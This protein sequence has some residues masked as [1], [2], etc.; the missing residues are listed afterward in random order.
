[1]RHNPSDLL[2]LDLRLE[3]VAFNGDEHLAQ[4]LG[5]NHVVQELNSQTAAQIRLLPGN[6]VQR[7]KGAE[8]KEQRQ[9][10]IQILEGIDEGGIALLDNVIEFDFGKQGQSTL[11]V[12]EILDGTIAIAL[13]GK[14]LW[15]IWIG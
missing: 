5:R 8:Q 13:L 4:R 1:M 3:V 9:T 11:Q 7:G 10:I 12:A 14:D 6:Q 2:A 15:N